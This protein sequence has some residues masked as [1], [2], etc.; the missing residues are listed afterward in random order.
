M[1][2]Y[3]TL[4]DCFYYDNLLNFENL[5]QP[6][7]AENKPKD[8]DDIGRLEP[9]FIRSELGYSDD[10]L[11]QLEEEKSKND[12]LLQKLEEVSSNLKNFDERLQNANKLNHKLQQ[13]LELQVIYSK[14]LKN[15]NAKFVRTINNLQS[16]KGYVSHLLKKRNRANERILRLIK[17]IKH[18]QNMIKNK[19]AIL[20]KFGH[21]YNLIVRKAS[22]IIKSR[23]QENYTV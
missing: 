21:N 2:I 15:I 7:P 1:T 12:K 3:E 9:T 23:I 10:L 14:N 11:L 5:E 17:T 8:I 20:A 16:Y 18:L 19:N 22:H 6:R 13:D 4:E